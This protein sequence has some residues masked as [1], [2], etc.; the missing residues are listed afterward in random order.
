MTT[1]A[2][3]QPK[4]KAAEYAK[5]AC[6][7]FVGCSINCSYCY[8]KTGRF[9]KTLG[10]NTPTLKKCFANVAIAYRIF[11]IEAL[12]N[13]EDL[14]KHGIFFSFT[15]DPMLPQTHQLTF[16]SMIFANQNKIPV[17]IL[18]KD[19]REFDHWIEMF[20]S[21][22]S[23]NPELIALGVSISGD[24]SQEPGAS[25]TYDRI[26]AILRLHHAGF[27]T[28][29][30]LEPAIRVNVIKR[31]IDMTL[32]WCDL[33]RIGLGV[34]TKQ[35][36]LKTAQAIMEEFHFYKKLN[37]TITS[38]FYLKD[39]FLNALN[40]NREDLDLDY[41]VDSDHTPF[42][43]VPDTAGEKEQSNE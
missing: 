22:P 12:E 35:E 18:T 17:Q 10:G 15:T 5:Y 38:K 16:L 21:F 41:F 25:C 6:N 31:V 3:Y 9:A 28:F 33:Y 42:T 26:T 1:K 27:R 20:Q 40:I 7:F 29:I 19:V 39:S 14:K 8:N 23:L 43:T 36:Q 24:S 11:Q 4:G 2:I 34:G 37:L 32:N 30:S 13:L